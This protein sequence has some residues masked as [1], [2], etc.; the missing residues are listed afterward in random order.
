MGKK[1][2]KK[3][4]IEQKDRKQNERYTEYKEKNKRE[5][6]K[7]TTYNAIKNKEWMKTK[8]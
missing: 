6:S 4:M 3:W 7:C 2:E 1:E 5:E 8:K